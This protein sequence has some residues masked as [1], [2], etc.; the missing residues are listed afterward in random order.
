MTTY[1]T[2]VLLKES[3]EGLLTNKSGVYVDLTFGG[4]GHSRFLLSQLHR[5]AKVFGFA[6]DKDAEMNAVSG[7]RF[8]FVQSNFCYL[9]NFMQYYGI[10]EVDGI[11]ADSG[12]S[13]HH[14]DDAECG[15]S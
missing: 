12:V 11:L 6:Q 7:S 2:P 5:D 1:H 9:E 15:L 4:G 8:T 13:S 10:K 14:F 3:I